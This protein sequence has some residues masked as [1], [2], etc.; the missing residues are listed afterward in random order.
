MA[1]PPVRRVARP[2]QR[3]CTQQARS[4]VRVAVIFLHAT[5]GPSPRG[6]LELADALTGLLDAGG[7]VVA[8]PIEGPWFDVGTPER[9]AE[10]ERS[11]SERDAAG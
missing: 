2:S 9:L 11:L 4:S 7:D 1:S 5:V 6:E 8:T 10:A 3:I